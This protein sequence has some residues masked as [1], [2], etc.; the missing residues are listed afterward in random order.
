[1]ECKIGGEPADLASGDRIVGIWGG[2]NAEH[3][4]RVQLVV[5]EEVTAA[6]G[7]VNSP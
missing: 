1:M 3:F 7:R 6:M 4:A 5:V 2:Q